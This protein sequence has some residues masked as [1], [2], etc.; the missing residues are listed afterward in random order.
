MI[1]LIAYVFETAWLTFSGTRVVRKYLASDR[2]TCLLFNIQRKT[3][4]QEREIFLFVGISGVM[5]VVCFK[6][7]VCKI[8]LA[9]PDGRRA[10]SRPMSTSA[11][12]SESKSKS[13][14]KLKSRS[15]GTSAV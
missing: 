11:S 2:A 9:H 14:F 13:K 1:R 5:A 12:E 3:S 7:Y 10:R 4:K 15:T 6:N 8:Q